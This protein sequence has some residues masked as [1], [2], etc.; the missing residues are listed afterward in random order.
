MQRTGGKNCGYL[1][2]II[3]YK[4]VITVKTGLSIGKG[5]SGYRIGEPDNPVIKHPDGRPYI[6]GSSL[7][8]RMRSLL[9][10]KYID[11]TKVPEKEPTNKEEREKWSFIFW[12][13]GA[14]IFAGP[15]PEEQ[16]ESNLA[17]VD[18]ENLKYLL[19]AFG[20]PIGRG[21]ENAVA[22]RVKITDAELIEGSEVQHIEEKPEVAIDRV[23]AAPNPRYNERVP[24]G[25][26]FEGYIIIDVYKDEN[27]RG[28]LKVLKEGFQLVAIHGLGGSTSRGYGQVKIEIEKIGEEWFCDKEKKGSEEESD[29]LKGTYTVESGLR[30]EDES[31]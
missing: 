26:K 28:I 3:I 30:S 31:K 4:Y 9:E 27:L 12:S 24:P 8:G 17:L 22:A 1:Q 2:G 18:K 20:S 15:V 23:T 29:V 13:G 7:K 19:K 16:E 14:R 6:P 5:R 10:Q 21:E 25:T 11:W